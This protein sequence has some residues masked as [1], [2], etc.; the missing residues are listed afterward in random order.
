MAPSTSSLAEYQY[1]YSAA[2][3]AFFPDLRTIV[4]LVIVNFVATP[5][6]YLPTCLLGTA[7]LRRAAKPTYLT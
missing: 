3:V 2:S 6:T 4:R 5:S 1:S 7:A